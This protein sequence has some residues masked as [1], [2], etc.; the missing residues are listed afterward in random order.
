MKLPAPYLL[1]WFSQRFFSLGI[2][3]QTGIWSEDDIVQEIVLKLSQMDWPNR[4]TWSRYHNRQCRTNPAFVIREAWR[5]AQKIKRHESLRLTSGRPSPTLK[6]AR[7][8]DPVSRSS[9]LEAIAALTDRQQA[10]L[11]LKVEL[12][13]PSLA[14]IA[15]AAGISRAT[16]CRDLQEARMLL[17]TAIQ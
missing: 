7:V 15:K 14:N 9:L 8:S 12:K 3:Y 1:D 6:D 2:R 13:D 17:E 10:V 5:V 16:A 4:P 11:R